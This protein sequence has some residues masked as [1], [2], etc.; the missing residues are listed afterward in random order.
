MA[1]RPRAQTEISDLL[2]RKY[3]KRI[4]ASSS[5][6]GMEKKIGLISGGNQGLGFETVWELASLAECN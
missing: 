5:E 1:E 6:F 2:E 4:P 3:A